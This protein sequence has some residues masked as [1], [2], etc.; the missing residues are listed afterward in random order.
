MLEGEYFLHARLR[1]VA[2]QRHFGLMR[3]LV[4]GFC[5][6]NQL[7]S[8]GFETSQYEAIWRLIVFRLATQARETHGARPW[9]L[10]WYCNMTP[11][12]RRQSRANTFWED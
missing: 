11:N 6:A 9:I 12:E 5:N 8:D 2:L 7:R 3:V 4:R 1:M 10:V